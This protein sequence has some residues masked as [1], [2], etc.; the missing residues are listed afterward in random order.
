MKRI[1]YIIVCLLV[2][3]G[4]LVATP[5]NL[6]YNN[7]ED[8]WYDYFDGIMFKNTCNYDYYDVHNRY[9]DKKSYVFPNN[10]IIKFS[11]KTYPKSQGKIVIPKEVRP[12]W[13]S[14]E[15]YGLMPGAFEDSD[16][17]TVIFQDLTKM[18]EIPNRAFYGSRLLKYCGTDKITSYISIG[19]SVF[20][21]CINLEHISF[22]RVKDIGKNTFKNCEKLEDFTVIGNLDKIGESVFEGCSNLKKLKMFVQTPPNISD[23]SFSKEI[24]ERVILIVLESS[25]DAYREHPVWGNFKNITTTDDAVTLYYSVKE[26]SDTATIIAPPNG[27]YSGDVMIPDEV[28]IDGKV[29]KVGRI[30]NQ[31]FKDSYLRSF[32]FGSN[33]TYIGESAFKQS[34]ITSI[35]I[36][37]TITKIGD[38]AFMDATLQEFSFA[39]NVQNLT[40]LPSG[41]LIGAKL[42]S[43]EIVLPDG[44]QRLGYWSLPTDITFVHLPSTMTFVPC[45]VFNSNTSLSV[46]ECAAVNPPEVFN[47]RPDG[48]YVFNKTIYENTILRVPIGSRKLYKDVAYWS[49]FKHIVEKDFSGVDV[50]PG[51]GGIAVVATES[52]IEVSGADEEAVAEVYTVSGQLVYRGI[53]R[54]IPVS[55]G[56]YIVRIAGKALKVAVK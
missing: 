41:F 36:P 45:Y 25:I 1:R 32:K 50:V 16:V 28:T 30:G 35:A 18:T 55:K 34:D 39:S 26:E 52:G 19:D 3:I 23:K 46:L 37:G 9:K 6:T 40:M 10:G 47:M 27:T 43:K 8:V 56:I 17:D 5:T 15:V 29:Y 14:S 33:I 49:W 12:W 4:I 42:M 53:E 51:N 31:A 7:S 2:S 48:D 54:Q 22:R 13:G 11:G 20:M 21:N 24:Y 44:V 38:D